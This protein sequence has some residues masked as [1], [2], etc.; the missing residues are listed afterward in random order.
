MPN[1]II[2]DYFKGKKS[3]LRSFV[4]A[5]D[6]GE[7]LW[8]REIMQRTGIP[9]DKVYNLLNKLEKRGFVKREPFVWPE[10]PECS[11]LWGK[12]RWKTWRCEV[13]KREGEGGFLGDRWRFLGITIVSIDE[14]LKLAALDL[15]AEEDVVMSSQLGFRVK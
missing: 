15:G 2:T 9:R 3:Y 8:V 6:V 10:P 12:R 11:N 14:L 13:T 7:A 1:N 4:D 5:V